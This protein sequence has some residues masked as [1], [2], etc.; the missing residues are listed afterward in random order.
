MLQKEN[1]VLVFID[2]QGKLAELVHEHET[3]FDRLHRLLAGMKALNVPVIVTEQLPDK[4]GP[5]REEFAEFITE[6]AITKSSFSCY[7]ESTFFQTL[8]KMNRRQVV[9]CG[10]ETHICVYQTAMDLLANDFEVTVLT[11]GVASRDP[12][13]KELALRRLETAGAKLS[14]LEMLLYEL[15]GDAKAPEFKS[16]LK[17][18]K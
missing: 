9:L 7:G 14:G 5:T 4:L 18:V 1:A 11:D 8:E 6:P 2:V 13:N 16:I 17:V 10:I 12:A 15:L 3:L